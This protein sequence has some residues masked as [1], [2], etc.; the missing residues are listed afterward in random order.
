MTE[1]LTATG[2]IT[3]DGVVGVVPAPPT[4]LPNDIRLQSVREGIA[5]GR[6]MGIWAEVV[7]LFDAIVSLRDTDKQVIDAVGNLITQ[8]TNAINTLR[9]QV[10]ERIDTTDATVNQLR[11]DST[12]AVLN[13]QTAVAGRLDSADAAINQLRADVTTAVGNEAAQRQSTD[14][15]I[16]NAIVAPTTGIWAR[17]SALEARLTAAGIA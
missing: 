6:D 17:L 7:E 14:D 10:A 16:T 13:L 15:G 1:P 11:T 12:N 4:T 2:T 8:A 3:A 9:S 5:A